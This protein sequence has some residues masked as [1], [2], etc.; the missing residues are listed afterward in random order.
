[1]RTWLT[2]GLIAFAA[3]VSVFVWQGWRLNFSDSLPVLI[4]VD[5]GPFD[6]RHSRGVFVRFCLPE[7]PQRQAFLDRGYLAMGVACDGIAPLTKRVYGIPGDHWRVTAD[8]VFVNGLR[9]PNTAP[10]AADSLGRALPSPDTKDGVVPSGHVLVLSSQHPR[11]LDSRYFG[12]IPT[13]QILN[14]VRPLWTV[15]SLSQPVLPPAPTGG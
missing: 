2:A 3:L 13:Q 1:M 15:A 8:G 6:A 12:P 10:L 14:N 7:S 4:W 11:S 5:D 9:V